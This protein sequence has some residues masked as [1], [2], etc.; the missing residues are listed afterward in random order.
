MAPH[1]GFAEL[2]LII[3]IAIIFAVDALLL[4]KGGDAATISDRLAVWSLK[5]PIVALLFGM[6]VGHLF[7]PNRG[8][9]P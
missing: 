6:L 2:F 7:W 5:Y 1:I 9:C 4:K 3:S 8:Y